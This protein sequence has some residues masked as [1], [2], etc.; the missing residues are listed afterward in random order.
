M[1]SKDHLLTKYQDN[2]STLNNSKN[3]NLEIL[4]ITNRIAGFF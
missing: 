4:Q 2:F 3:K 1:T